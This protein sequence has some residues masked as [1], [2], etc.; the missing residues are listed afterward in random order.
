[1]VNIPP[2]QTATIK[3]VDRARLRQFQEAVMCGTQRAVSV[4]AVHDKDPSCEGKLLVYA[5]YSSDRDALLELDRLRQFIDDHFP[6]SGID[7][8]L[9]SDLQKPCFAVFVG[10]APPSS[11]K[12]EMGAFFRNFGRLH[13]C[14]PV[15]SIKVYD[16]CPVPCLRSQ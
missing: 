4:H 7:A 5:N 11:S 3:G 6:C 12:D 2:S 1:M 8:M 16:R 15:A 13:P 9:K 10:N 14:T